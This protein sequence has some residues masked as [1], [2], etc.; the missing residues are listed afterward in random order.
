[1]I[2]VV[3]GK[4]KGMRLK[5][6]SDDRVRTIPQKIKESLFSILHDRI[7]GAVVLDGFSGTGSIGI[8]ALSRGA[9]VVVFVDEFPAATKVIQDNVIKCQ[10]EDRSRII[11]MEFNRAVIQLAKE[12]A[13]F[14]LIFLDPPYRLL[15]N[16]NPCKVIWKRGILKNGG[17]IVLRRFY[18]TDFEPKYY[19]LKHEVTLGDDT[20]SF[21][22]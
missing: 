5:R 22:G 6:V 7:K 14:D 12:K 21:Y 1:M 2:R 9:D 16:R 20:L 15:E 4:Y 19:D 8:E 17:Q 13:K 11:R 18:K 10:A 3:A